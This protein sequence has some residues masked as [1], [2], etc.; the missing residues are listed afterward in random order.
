MH[1]GCAVTYVAPLATD[2]S[3]GIDGIDRGD[4]FNRW[5]PKE[6]GDAVWKG[7]FNPATQ[8][9]TAFFS[10]TCR[11]LVQQRCEQKGCM[12]GSGL[13][14]RRSGGP[15]G[16][17]LID[18]WVDVWRAWLCRGSP[19]N[20]HADHSFRVSWSACNAAAQTACASFTGIG[21]ATQPGCALMPPHVMGGACLPVAPVDATPTGAAYV[22][23]LRSFRSTFQQFYEYIGIVGGSYNKT[24]ACRGY[25]SSGHCRK[26]GSGCHMNANQQTVCAPGT[27]HSTPSCCI[28][29]TDEAHGWQGGGLRWLAVQFQSTL[30]EEQPQD[31][32]RSVMDDIVSFVA[33]RNALAPA[34][35]GDAFSS[36]RGGQFAWA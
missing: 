21:C 15:S 3:W 4:K 12:D 28:D 14:V 16:R 1:L 11:A 33:G 23:S 31:R 30:E 32:V 22:A 6:R 26:H 9:A 27:E 20:A 36:E 18:C 25:D 13:L 17:P 19:P 2:I 7:S 34:S 10:K 35:A 5:V 29:E 24:R 8:A